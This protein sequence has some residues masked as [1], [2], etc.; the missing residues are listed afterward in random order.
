ME[1]W[2]HVWRV[3]TIGRV[4]PINGIKPLHT[5]KHKVT[6]DSNHRLGVAA[7]W[8]DGDFAADAPHRK[9]AGGITYY[10]DIRGVALPSRHSRSA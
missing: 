2:R 9:W 6:T 10:L 7:N 4:M 3:E 8:L 5:R 1:S